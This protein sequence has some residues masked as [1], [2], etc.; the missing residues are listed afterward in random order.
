[1]PEF[2]IEILSEEIPARFQRWAAAAIKRYFLDAFQDYSLSSPGHNFAEGS[3]CTPRRLVFW[4][5]NLPA[6]TQEM[7]AEVRGPRIGA[8][9][10]ALEGF[11]R[12][13]DIAMEALTEREGFY[14]YTKVVPS[15]ATT[16]VLPLLVESILNKFTWP[17]SMR[18]GKGIGDFGRA[19]VRPIS[20]IAALYEGQIVPIRFTRVTS[21]DTTYG[22]YFMS[23]NAS[24][25]V[26]S[27]ADYQ[28]KLRQNHVIFSFEERTRSILQAATDFAKQISAKGKV[29]KAIMDEE[30]LTEVA[31]L[32]E[33]PKAFLSRIDERFL[34]LPKE[35]LLTSA[36]NHQRYFLFEDEKSELA[37]YFMLIANSEYTDNATV[38]AGHERVLRGR[39]ADAEFF[40]NNDLKT[41]L[42]Q[43]RARLQQSVFHSDIGTMEDKVKRIRTLAERL[44]QSVSIELEK[45]S[46]AVDLCKCDLMSEMVTEFPELEGLMGYYY[47]KAEGV[48]DSVALAI[49]EH[50]KPRGPHDSLPSNKVGA[51]VA[52]ADKLD[53]LIQ[54]FG[55][56]IKPTGNGDPFAQRR[57]KLGIQRIIAHYK[58]PID[59]KEFIS[60]P[61]L[62]QFFEL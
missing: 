26:K 33:Y 5:Q 27:L 3:E 61:E 22:H 48:D 50:Y 2:F 21:A 16:E 24:L 23:N 56:G 28:E 14:F 9:S 54:L 52:I 60:N 30:L 58:L 17:K 1:M 25:R 8:P 7:T 42:Q 41:G 47:A 32:I 59:L 36:K 18:W 11:L 46:Q 12:K 39:L 43:M 34:K 53:S 51:I 13:Y 57:A 10:Q 6:Q 29:Y 15:C 44:A 35:V 40:Y 62:L 55:I 38:I 19:W 45:V 20:S 37:P 4:A 49:K 31:G